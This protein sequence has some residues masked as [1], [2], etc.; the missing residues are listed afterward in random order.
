M[1]LRTI[2]GIGTLLGFAGVFYCGIW[3]FADTTVMK[4]FGSLA[5]AGILGI[6]FDSIVREGI[7]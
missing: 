5:I 3:G 1:K 6:I 2:F 4:V 7:E